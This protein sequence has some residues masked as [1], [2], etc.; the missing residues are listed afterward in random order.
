MPV[1]NKTVRKL[2][3][4]ITELKDL[5]RKETLEKE[6]ILNLHEHY[7]RIFENSKDIIYLSSREGKI[8]EINKAAVDLFGYTKEELLKL[9]I[10]RDLYLHPSDRKK[11]QEKIEK[12]GFVKDYEIP[13][14]RKDGTIIYVSVTAN[15]IKDK[16]GKILGYEGIL[17]DITESEMK[18][19]E[20][21]LLYEQTRYLA[22]RDHL[23][24]LF[25]RR[26]ATELL[27]QEVERS[28][29]AGDAFS[30]MMLDVDDLK[31]VNDTW[32]HDAGDKVLK[33]VAHILKDTIRKTDF[34]CRYGGDEFLVILPHT[35]GE[36]A[37]TL[38]K[39]ISNKIKNKRIIVDGTPL[40]VRL[41]I[42]I[43]TYPYDSI[44][45]VELIKIADRA[46][47]ESKQSK[48]YAVTV[49]APEII[50][51][52]KS[53][54]LSIPILQSL[55]NVI[56]SKDR[57]TKVHSETVAHYAGL[58]GKCLNLSEAQMELLSVAA[59]LHD[60]G[61]IGIPADVLNKAGSLSEDEWKLIR[62]HPLLGATM[63]NGLSHKGGEDII[64]AI[65]YHHERYNGKG[66]PRGLKG[67]D[68]PLLA[69][70]LAVA[71]AY[72]S[73]T[74]ERPY[75]KALT[76]DE[77]IEELK[78]QSGKQFDPDIVSAFIECLLKG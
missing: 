26:R 43:A 34:A 2:S 13:M 50:K 46:M 8:I 16:K 72:S 31:T 15:V 9:D 21:S 28:K 49:S 71:D 74:A 25:N 76:K 56:A 14:K 58:I 77:A 59:I 51:F 65:M 24:G 29:R 63:I 40:T 17:R 18:K 53:E 69:R 55:I 5:L 22:E 67:K 11:F 73:M 42:G 54:P 52:L 37:K 36:K 41:S 62:Q 33:E 39:R 61:K 4:K 12:Q 20:I 27:E 44:L 70:I 48:K 60:L 10:A 6:R 75:R 47:Y 19:K 78:K 66:Y 30:I 7:K 57:Y 3:E 45:P 64:G 35:H 1:V 32:G 38:A 23:T 68:I